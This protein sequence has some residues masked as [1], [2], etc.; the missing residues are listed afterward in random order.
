MT[1]PWRPAATL[2]LPAHS[3]EFD[4]ALRLTQRQIPLLSRAVIA[5]LVA[6]C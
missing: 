1:A 2:L 6:G 5:L 3:G 4:A